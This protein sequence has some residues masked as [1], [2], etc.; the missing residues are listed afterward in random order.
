MAAVPVGDSPLVVA[1]VA[2]MVVVV[3]PVV[4]DGPVVASMAA[5]PVRD[6]PVVVAVVASMVVRSSSSS[7]SR[8]TRTSSSR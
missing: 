3:V 7:S 5:V 8:C 1:V 2:S 4:V 6:S